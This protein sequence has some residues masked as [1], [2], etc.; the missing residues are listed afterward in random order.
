[1]YFPAGITTFPPP[2][3]DAF[4]IEALMSFWFC[5]AEFFSF[6]ATLYSFAL[7]VGATI[8]DSISLY[9]VF[10][11][12]CAIAYKGMRSDTTH[13]AIAFLIVFKGFVFVNIF[14]FSDSMCCDLHLSCLWMIQVFFV[15]QHYSKYSENAAYSSAKIR[16]FF[17]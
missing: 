9:V 16:I 3:F 6:T 14:C 2:F 7:K 15:S 4:K 10:Q 13:I 5:R 12:S 11:A 1:M 17:R 8:L